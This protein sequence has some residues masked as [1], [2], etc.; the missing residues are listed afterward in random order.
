MA[1][2]CH[3]KPVKLVIMLLV[4]GVVSVF[5]CVGSAW[6]RRRGECGM[7]VC[8]SFVDYARDSLHQTP[9]QKHLFLAWW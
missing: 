3:D 9:I 6:G 4:K 2:V 8:V 1:H 5:V 7:G